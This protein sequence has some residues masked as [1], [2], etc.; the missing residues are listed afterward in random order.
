VIEGGPATVI[1]FMNED[2]D[3]VEFGGNPAERLH[4]SEAMRM[5]EALVFASADPVTDSVS[6]VFTSSSQA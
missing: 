4:L 3:P 2:D 1:P 6:Q 5:A